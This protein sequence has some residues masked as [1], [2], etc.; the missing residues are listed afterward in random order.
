MSELTENQKKFLC[1][2]IE[3]FFRVFV[4]SDPD[5]EDSTCNCCEEKRQFLNE[6]PRK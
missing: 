4:E 3:R 1:A 2:N 5:L 6:M